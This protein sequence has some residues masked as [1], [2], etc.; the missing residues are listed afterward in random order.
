[1][2]GDN[3]SAMPTCRNIEDRHVY[4][5]VALAY[6]NWEGIRMLR[7]VNKRLHTTSSLAQAYR[8]SDM[9]PVFAF[10]ARRTLLGALA[11]DPKRKS[12]ER[13]TEALKELFFAYRINVRLRFRPS[14]YV[15]TYFSAVFHLRLIQ[16]TDP[17]GSTEAFTGIGERSGEEHRPSRTLTSRYHHYGFVDLT[18]S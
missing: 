5:Q 11:N 8:H 14:G 9:E 2:G 16:S 17:A 12:L 1:M 18:G 10:F 4:I 3:H 15:I 7:V 6:T 13:M